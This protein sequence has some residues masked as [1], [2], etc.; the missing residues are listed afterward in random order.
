MLK[1]FYHKDFLMKQLF[2]CMAALLGACNNTPKSDTSKIDD[3][4]ST[5]LTDTSVA[6]GTSTDSPGDTT[7][8][9]GSFA[10]W[11]N[12]DGEIFPGEYDTT[13]QVFVVCASHL[14]VKVNRDKVRFESGNCDNGAPTRISLMIIT[15]DSARLLPGDLVAVDTAAG[16][17]PTAVF[18]V[19]NQEKKVI[20]NE[21]QYSN[22]KKVKA[23]KVNAHLVQPK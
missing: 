16:K 3:T 9:A 23:R 4:S 18:R 19:N 10:K 1:L 20:L 11:T 6:S 5:S 15:K 2:V 12:D 17:I 22:I 7:V 21:R 8:W 14:T 13:N